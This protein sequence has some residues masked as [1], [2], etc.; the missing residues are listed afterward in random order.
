VTTGARLDALQGNDVP[1]DV[2]HQRWILEHVLQATLVD[3]SIADAFSAVTYMLAH[4]SA[5]T[6]RWSSERLPP[7]SAHI[8]AIER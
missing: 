7:M 5:L 1:E 3:Q 8:S 4:P 2:A 6:R